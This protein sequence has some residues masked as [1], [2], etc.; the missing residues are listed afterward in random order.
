MKA[1]I[2]DAHTADEY[3]AMGAR[4]VLSFGP[5]LVAQGELVDYVMSPKYYPYH[6]PRLA[7][8]MIE[9]YHYMILAV[10]GREDG[11][12]G[13]KLDWM[14]E[15]MK[16]LGCTEAL[17][18]DGGGTAALMFMGEVLNRSDKDMRSVSTLIGF[19]QS[20]KVVGK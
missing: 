19:G 2:S 4:H 14:A 8:G 12:K 13:A 16:E 6:E 9:P 11:S 3:L 17:N 20:E 10:E 5:M 1:F 15:K 18:L 7:I